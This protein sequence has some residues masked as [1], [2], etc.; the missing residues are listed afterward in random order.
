MVVLD[1]EH[2]EGAETGGDDRQQRAVAQVNACAEHGA[3]G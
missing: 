1:A 2:R 3:V